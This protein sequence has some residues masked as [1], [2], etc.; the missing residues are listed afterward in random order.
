M[1][2]GLTKRAWVFIGTILLIIS[3]SIGLIVFDPPT[4]SIVP[5][6]TASSTPVP[7]ITPLEFETA[8]PAAVA[9]P[10]GQLY[11]VTKVVDGD[12]IKVDLDGTIEMVRIVGINTPETVDPRK[13]V[14]CM[15]KEASDFA[16]TLLTGQLVHLETDPTQGDRDRYGRLLRFVFLQDGTDVGKLLIEQ[17]F[18][19]ESLYSSKP[20]RF[21]QSYLDAQREAQDAQKGLWN[22]ATC[23]LAAE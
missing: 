6:P 7:T 20:H 15:G 21:R 17:G 23:P 3:F 16:K 19:H 11:L 1:N 14:E 13:P 4:I 22:P 5:I 10:A 9:S 2:N 8:T 12:T 18:A